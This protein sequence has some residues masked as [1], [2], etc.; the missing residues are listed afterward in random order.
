M[1]DTIRNNIAFAVPHEDIDENRLQQAIEEALVLDEATSALDTDTETA[2]MEAIDHLAGKTTL[3]IAHR[4]T[5]IKNCDY[6]Y[7][8]KDGK[9]LLNKKKETI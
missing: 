7:E 2:V 4:L 9:V 3:I 5:T 1:D 8:V 6:I